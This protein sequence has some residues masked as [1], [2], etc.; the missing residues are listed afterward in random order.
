M[1]KALCLL[2]L[3]SPCLTFSESDSRIL[4]IKEILSNSGLKT[5]L[6]FASFVAKKKREETST[7]LSKGYLPVV[8]LISEFERHISLP[9]SE[10]RAKNYPEFQKGCI[11]VEK[12]QRDGMFYLWSIKRQ[13]GFTLTD[14]LLFTVEYHFPEEAPS[15]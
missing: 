6:L 12:N 13:D 5:P 4:K 2:L 10:E 11:I 7:Q 9:T 1:I 15:K 14:K 3:F 8:C